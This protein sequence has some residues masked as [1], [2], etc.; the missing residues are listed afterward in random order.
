MKPRSAWLSPAKTGHRSASI[1]HLGNIGY[2]LGRKLK[3]DPAK[4]DFLG[5]ADAS[6]EL[7]REAQLLCMMAGANSLFFGDRLLTTGNPAWEAD[8][9]LLADA[10]VKALEPST[11]APARQ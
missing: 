6:K 3:W 9:A 1:C 2:R 11:V 10:G 4:E 7:T 5:D 8:K